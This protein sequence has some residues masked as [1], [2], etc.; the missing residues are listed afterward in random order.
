MLLF[1]SKRKQQIIKAIAVYFILTIGA[2][3]I[4]LPVA[5]MVS[6]ALK[7]S[8][9]IFLFPPQWI[10]KPIQWDNFF[11]A[12]NAIPFWTFLKNTLLI[13]A[14]GLV[15]QVASTAIVGFGF[16]RLDF[17]G[18]DILFLLVLSTM[19]LPGIVTMIPVFMMF[20]AWGWL[21]TFKPLIVPS[22]FGGGAFYIFVMRQF[23]MTIPLELDEAA[24]IDGCGT[25]KIFLHILLPLARPALLTIA[26]FSFL[27]FWS[28]FMGPLI[29][30]NDTSKFTIAL[31]L[32][33]FRGMFQTDWNLL[34]A[35]SIIV[36]LPCVILFFFT[37]KQF[38]QGI[39]VSGIKG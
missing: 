35:A 37:Q 15:G 38:I 25:F 16:A 23:F 26:I 3:I 17:P 21:D 10:P 33:L 14:F 1:A 4:L 7:D 39:V 9:A 32:N 22:Y 13:T 29:Y 11:K 2:A 28:D 20:K 19:M 36:M 30:L 18:R 8:G 5:W 12:V 27:G 6:T 24:R 34:M 31:G